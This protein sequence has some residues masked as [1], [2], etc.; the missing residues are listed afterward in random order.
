MP[1]SW[2][3]GLKGS[4]R[5]VL[6]ACVS[7]LKHLVDQYP[8]T[9]YAQG[10]FWERREC[11]AFQPQRISCTRYAEVLGAPRLHLQ[12]SHSDHPIDHPT[13]HHTCFNQPR[14][15]GPAPQCCTAGTGSITPRAR[16]QCMHADQHH[17]PIYHR[18]L[19]L[20]Q[21]PV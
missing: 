1:A 15:R 14:C 9:L 21:C 4:T 8:H 2:P 17:R 16:M 12:E 3:L 6:V 11:G 13:D 7:A 19:I 20:P 18:R 10:D 5:S